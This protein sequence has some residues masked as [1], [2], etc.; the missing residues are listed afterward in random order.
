MR[1]NLITSFFFLFLIIVTTYPLIF[2]I[3]ACIPGFFS[4]DEPF[5][6]MW[7]SWQIKYSF[8][9]QLPLRNTLLIAY[10]YG[11][12]LYASGYFSYLGD[13]W[14]HLLS[15]FTT[16]IIT[17]NIQILLNLFLSAFFSYLLVFYLTKN[18]LSGILGGII[19]GFCPYQFMR[20]WQHLGLTY[21]EWLSLVLL[22][23]ILFWEKQIIRYGIFFFI[24]LLF[25]FSFDLSVMY[26]GGVTL[27]TFL[28]Y[29]LI[30]QGQLKLLK[31][32]DLFKFNIKFISKTIGIILLALIILFPQFFPLIKGR[33]KLSHTTT[34]S[35]FN[36]YHRPF[37]DLFTQSARPLS[38]FLPPVVHPVFGKFTQMFIGSPLY[39]VSFTEHTLY[40]GW[41]P[42]ILTFLAFRR[43]RRV[44]KL[45]INNDN[46][47]DYFYIG[48]FIFLAI[49]AWFFSQPP[50]WRIGSV[51]IFMP[52]FFMY[53]ILPMYRAYCRFGIV[54]MLAVAVLSGYGLKFLL[55]RFKTQKTKILVASFFCG[56]V[57]FEFWNWPP[58]K[59]I[60]VSKAPYV[61]Y[62]LRNQPQEFIVAEYPLDIEAPN[63]MYKF[64]Q[65]FHQKPIINCTIPGTYANKVGKA[66]AKLSNPK[67][68][69]V[70]KW[71]G[72]KYVLVHRENYLKTELVEQVEELK[73]IPHNPYLRFIKSFPS[74][75]CPY[76]NIMC[77]QKTDSIDVYE[78]IAEPL[79]PMVEE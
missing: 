11:R 48:F 31:R 37:D 55:E 28:F 56:V 30:Y 54:V 57:L 2:K 36:P 24:S 13:G 46:Y 77:T 35:A 26:F 60:D 47:R 4:T 22:G 6:L 76:K 53:R 18:R 3:S 78:V 64:Y 8:K 68:A 44:K 70:L 71:I 45:G 15:I 21:N 40:L 79:I 14:F 19:F 41:V 25:L 27:A 51:K 16:P 74:Q 10:P 33:I 72:V 23:I 43:W 61:Y 65:I 29:I 38:Y 50:W 62:W 34:A 66:I 7:R 67:T 63:E 59:V 9:N 1:K 49:V 52:S 20:M 58:F 75:D 69:S 12:D 73:R 32:R 17:W 39:G 5:G 42:L